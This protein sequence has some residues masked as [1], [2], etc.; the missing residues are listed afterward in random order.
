MAKKLPVV[1]VLSPDGS[2]GIDAFSYETLKN[3]ARKAARSI[4][5]PLTPENSA[6]QSPTPE[7]SEAKPKLLCEAR[8][9]TNAQGK[10]LNAA[11]IHATHS[12]VDF[13]IKGKQVRYPMDKLSKQS[14]QMIRE[15]VN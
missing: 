9:W 13:L 6:E 3:D 11:I 5:L 8:N 4:E 12:H 14:Q 1:F 7:S 2:K 15:L 10:T